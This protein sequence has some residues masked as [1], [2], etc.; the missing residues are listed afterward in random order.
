MHIHAQEIDRKSET[1]MGEIHKLTLTY[2]GI[3][4][5]TPCNSNTQCS[6]TM[7]YMCYHVLI[8]PMR[9]D[10][11]GTPPPCG[12]LCGTATCS[13]GQ[14]VMKIALRDTQKIR[15]AQCSPASQELWGPCDTLCVV[16]MEFR[17]I[18]MNWGFFSIKWQIQHSYPVPNNNRGSSPRWSIL[19][20]SFLGISGIFRDPCVNSCNLLYL[21]QYIP[22]PNDNR[23]FV[24]SMEHFIHNSFWRHFR[25]FPGPLC[26]FLQFYP[27]FPIT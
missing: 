16:P 2:I 27:I 17:W 21:P 6:C 26:E 4:H 5:V 18:E 12:V 19:Y 20:T 24:T 13:P 1:Y 25:D 9:V 8:N 3:Q 23:G 10:E 7:L 14:A 11:L 15:R 22:V